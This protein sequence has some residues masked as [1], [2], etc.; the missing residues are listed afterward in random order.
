MKKEDKEQGRGERWLQILQSP[1]TKKAS[2][3]WT[4][5]SPSPPLQGENFSVVRTDNMSEEWKIDDERKSSSTATTF[6]QILSERLG[7][8]EF[9]CLKVWRAA[10]AELLGMAALVF[11]IDTIVISSF[12]TD[13]K[14]PNILIAALVSLTVTIL[15]LAIAPVSGGH[16]NPLISF[17]A[18]LLGLISPSRAAIYI[19]AQCIGE[20][21]GA[22]G[23]KAVASAA[24]E[25]N[26]SLGG[27][28]LTVITPGPNG[29]IEVGID[30][31]TGLWL[32]IIC[33][34]VL[35][36]AVGIAFDIRQLTAHGPV[37]VCSI[38]GLLIGLLAFISTT[39]TAKRGYAGAG[40]NPARCIGPAIVRGGHLWQG[41]WVFWAGPAIASM[42]FYIYT[43]II[44][45]EIFQAHEF[46]YDSFTT[47]KVLTRRNKK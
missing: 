41:H 12:D 18:M 29:P 37:V 47:L 45:S 42:A 24:V 31:D 27:C 5:S 36:Y 9:F 22:L 44:P 40:M 13:T 34:F 17:S 1:E 32:E 35:L 6:G 20:V 28:T 26:F 2:N 11:L 21:I 19:M 16:I 14:T 8:R 25:S 39:L 4:E 43:K 46:K 3:P 7:L 15:I 38:I 30:T 23:L 10:V 33:S